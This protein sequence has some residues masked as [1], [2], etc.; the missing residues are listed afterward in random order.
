MARALR[1]W[2]AILVVACLAGTLTACS[3]SAPPDRSVS[4][5][6]FDRR[7]GSALDGCG[8]QIGDPGVTRTSQGFIALRPDSGGHP[9]SVTVVTAQCVLDEL[10]M[11]RKHDAEFTVDSV[12]RRYGSAGWDSILASWFF[13]DTLDFK[14]DIVRS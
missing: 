2:S 5:A 13:H 8:L 6:A 9:T 12:K 11:P 7:V 3:A 14:V 4:K 1:P 10:G